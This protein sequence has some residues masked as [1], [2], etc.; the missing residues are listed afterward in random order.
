MLGKLVG[1]ERLSQEIS[2]LPFGVYVFYNQFPWIYQ[3][4]NEM[5]TH[6]YV[7][8]TLRARRILR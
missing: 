1:R 2:P 5:V 7:L 3:V 6:V 4:S 8:G